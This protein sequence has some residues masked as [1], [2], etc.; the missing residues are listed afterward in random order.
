MLCHVLAGIAAKGRSGRMGFDQTG[1]VMRE[2]LGR[3]WEA[4]TSQRQGVVRG[5]STMV[6]E[7][8]AAAKTGD[9][10]A[11][12]FLYVRYSPEV[13]RY[14][15][16]LVKDD[17]EAEDITQ[18]VFL[19]LMS[20]I[21]RYQPREVP[22]SAWILRVARNAALDYLRARRATPV[23]TVRLNDDE[24]GRIR[25]ERGN[26]LRQALELLPTE[27]R[28]VLILRHVVGL[29]PAEIATALGRT[30]SSVHGLHHRG[31]NALQSSLRS[32]G[33][34][35]VVAERAAPAG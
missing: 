17:H 23:E 15:R 5:D 12:H 30:E 21:R 26:D 6:R 16:G 34:V 9:R 4:G 22:F 14:V 10:D 31:R 32:L 13:L 3:S 7:A 24:G 1:V 25:H 29:S 2:Q 35:P 28:D 19:K 27:Q 20:S 18:G 11:I 8:I 33:A